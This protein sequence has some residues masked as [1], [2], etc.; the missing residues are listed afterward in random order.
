[1]LSFIEIRIER[2]SSV[3]MFCAKN[4]QLTQQHS[5]VEQRHFIVL[6]CRM[7]EMVC[8]CV[9]LFCLH[10]NFMYLISVVSARFENSSIVPIS[11]QQQNCIKEKNVRIYLVPVEA[12]RLQTE[13]TKNN[14][15]KGE[16]SKVTMHKTTDIT[17]N[18]SNCGRVFLFFISFHRTCA[19]EVVKILNQMARSTIDTSSLNWIYIYAMQRVKIANLCLMEFKMRVHG[20]LILVCVCVCTIHH[21][22]T[23]IPIK[24]LC[25]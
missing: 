12:P 3:S 17:N 14:D 18:K 22:A 21:R 20:L 23:K 15:R 10:L 5:R 11:E 6:T 1:M 2:T 4:T 7:I 13:K 8:V 25:F 16:N 9:C 24:I 19:N